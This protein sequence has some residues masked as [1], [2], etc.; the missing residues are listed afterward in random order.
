MGMG[1]LKIIWGSGSY[2]LAG[3]SLNCGGGKDGDQMN[4]EGLASID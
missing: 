4:E 3:E 1:G 2:Q